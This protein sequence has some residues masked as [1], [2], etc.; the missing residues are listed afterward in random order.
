MMKMKRDVITAEHSSLYEMNQAYTHYFEGLNIEERFTLVEAAYAVLGAMGEGF[1]I[2]SVTFAHRDTFVDSSPMC[3]ST[4]EEIE[5][6]I[7]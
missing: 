3:L 7:S 2:G 1:I 6:I 5:K 4:L